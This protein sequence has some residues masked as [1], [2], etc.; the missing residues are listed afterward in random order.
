METGTVVEQ[1]APLTPGP[2]RR[3]TWLAGVAVLVVLGVGAA[4]VARSLQASPA[5]PA[6]NLYKVEYAAAQTEIQTQGTIESE[7]EIN[8]S[9]QG[10]GGKIVQLNAKVGDHVHAGQLL[11]AVDD[12]AQRAQLAA[13]QAAEAQ[14]E[15]NLAAAQARLVQVTEGPTQATVAVA[16][17]NVDK[18]KAALAAAQQQY[19]DQ[20]A[21][22]DDRTAAYQQVVAAQN[23][24]N[25]AKAALDM[26]QQNQSAN[27]QA[28][29]SELSAAQQQL[30]TAQQNYQ[31][32]QQQ[33]GNITE[34]Q[35]KQAYQDY[36]N[37]LASYQSYQKNGFA[38]PNP[39]A[40]VLQ[41][42][43]N[44]Y[45]G[46]N[47]GYT[48]LQQAQQAYTSA[49]A[50]VAKAQ[51]DLTSAQNA[52]STAQAQ[53]DAAQKNLE[54][55]QQ[56]YNDRTQAKTALDNAASAVQQAEAALKNAQAAYQQTVQPPDQGSLQ[57]A[58]A[59]VQTAQAGVQTA[60][61][62]LQAAQVAEDN[63]QLKAPADGVITQKLHDAGDVVAPNQPVFVLDVKQLQVN[64]QVSE[65]Q[66]HFVHP[67]DTLTMTVPQLPG[68]TLTGKVFEV[69]PTPEPGNPSTYDVKATLNDPSGQAKPG[70]TGQVTLHVGNQDK[71]ILLPTMAL[72]T[73]N[74]QTG[75]FVVSRKGSAGAPG[76][77][78]NS[79]AANGPQPGAGE[80]AT[81]NLTVSPAFA[82]GSQGSGAAGSQVRVLNLP[83][84]VVFR[85][86]TV[87]SWGTFESV[88]SSGL[89][90]GDEVLLGESKFVAGT[91]K[92][93]PSLTQSGQ[94]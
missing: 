23:A 27:I 59:G 94:G 12:S 35:V 39:Y 67:G 45:Q 1:S 89:Q 84:G 29:Q 62:Q 83:P 72:Y 37:A 87:S 70:M 57:A 15:G 80:N 74:G 2:K 7:S 5:I 22:Y 93:D 82:G 78:S 58:Q 21:L 41:S 61:A 33:Y 38:G 49:Q 17:S 3:K 55:A 42:T 31:Q 43:L 63:T 76:Q 90:P 30:A 20:K 28:A 46:L 79:A 10:S 56:V 19:Q 88:I 8:L 40:G 54:V 91:D 24:V 13:A 6:S 16:Q 71:V 26:A 50:A 77:A 52:V 75:V 47:T 86:V 14:A 73:V 36:L 85:P 53:Y 65:T 51:S 25:Q 69:Y 68:V 44:V 34:D 92:L 18:A 11:A 32:A 66:V 64:V 48:A 9:F 60:Q 81:G 4:V